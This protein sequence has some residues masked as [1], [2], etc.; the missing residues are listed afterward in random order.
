M[1]L[2]VWGAKPTLGLKEMFLQDLPWE[3][4][5]LSSLYQAEQDHARLG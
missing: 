5:M 2:V 3:L 4:S 1:I